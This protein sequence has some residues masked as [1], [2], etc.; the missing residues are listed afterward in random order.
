MHYP[1]YSISALLL[2]LLFALPAQ[3]A[4]YEKND[5]DCEG[6]FCVDR[7]VS[8][9]AGDAIRKVNVCF[10]Q[11]NSYQLQC[12]TT[13]KCGIKFICDQYTAHYGLCRIF[14]HLGPN[15]DIPCTQEELNAFMMGS[16]EYYLIYTLG[17]TSPCQ[18]PGC[19]WLVVLEICNTK[20][21][22]QD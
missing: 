8:T 11:H 20:C 2:V 6:L 9:P 13:C 22:T 10:L 7:L 1:R 21:H 17:Y 14:K 19:A 15:Q 4:F 3:A 16:P 18:L 5:P 12:H